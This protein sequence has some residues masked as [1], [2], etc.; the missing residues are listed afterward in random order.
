MRGSEDTSL[1][2][3]WWDGPYS[4][5]PH[6]PTVE[7]QHEHVTLKDGNLFSLCGFRAGV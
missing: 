3:V 1:T 4:N 6:D 2:P 7:A 5:V